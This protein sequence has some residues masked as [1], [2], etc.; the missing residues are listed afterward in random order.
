M[1]NLLREGFQYDLWANLQWMAFLEGK[2][3]P[4]Q[5]WKILQHILGAQDNWLQ[6]CQGHSP[7]AMPQP[8]VSDASMR[9]LHQAWLELLSANTNDPIIHYRRIAGD[10]LQQR[11]SRIA[12][13]VI[14][15]GAYHRGELRGLC[16]VRDD[17]DFPEAGLAGFFIAEGLV[18]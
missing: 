7:T 14:D 10:A 8:E 9:N 11:V 3:R 5:D 6:R 12:R 4:E 17:W 13:H 1:F 16:L 15:H 18:D 2:G